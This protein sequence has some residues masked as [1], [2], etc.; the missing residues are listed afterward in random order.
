MHALFSSTKYT[1]LKFSIKLILKKGKNKINHCLSYKYF[2]N[3]Q[4]KNILIFF[5][6]F[7]NLFMN[8]ARSANIPLYKRAIEYNPLTLVAEN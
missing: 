6:V 4:N 7:R 1:E 5:S 8:N 2:C 3:G